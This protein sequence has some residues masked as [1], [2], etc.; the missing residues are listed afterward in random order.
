MFIYLQGQ[1][2]LASPAYFC[3]LCV[4]VGVPA[5]YI[6]TATGTLS[7]ARPEYLHHVMTCVASVCLALPVLMVNLLHLAG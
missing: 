3:C 2:S 7:S 6:S 5:A 1:V 4:L